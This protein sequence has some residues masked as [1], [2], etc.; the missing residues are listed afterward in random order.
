MKI[1]TGF[2]SNSSS[3]SFII[4]VGRIVDKAM[5]LAFIKKN[6]I[7]D[8]LYRIE[9][10]SE[11][12]K[13]NLSVESFTGENVSLTIDTAK[14][15]EFVIIDYCGDEGDN[16]FVEDSDHD[17][18]DLDYDINVSFFEERYAILMSF[19]KECGVEDF[20]CSYGAGRNW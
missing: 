17:N 4:G 9:S 13:H 10:T 2:V 5:F 11:I 16:Y 12:C 19:N 15:E 7:Q 14:E 3:S 1:R 8:Y 18:Y 20:Q 6:N